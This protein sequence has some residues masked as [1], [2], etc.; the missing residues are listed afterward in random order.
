MLG[1]RSWLINGV[2]SLVAVS[3]GCASDVHRRLG[4]AHDGGTLVVAF[5]DATANVSVTIDGRLVCS[6]ETTEK[7]VVTEVP[8]GSRRVVVSGGG[9]D[10]DPL[11]HQETIEIV[12][13]ETRTMTVVAPSQS[14]ASAITTIASILLI[15][16]LVP[17]LFAVGS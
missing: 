17:G 3:L 16:L 6:D 13:G 14:T 9:G 11:R 15:L 1:K 7:V 4:D 10:R 12:Q 8:A 5:T 2:L